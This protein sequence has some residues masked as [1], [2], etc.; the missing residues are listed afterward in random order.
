MVE[1]EQTLKKR[2]KIQ[3]FVGIMAMVAVS[4]FIKKHELLTAPGWWERWCP[5]SLF[6][7]IFEQEKFCLERFL[8]S[9]ALVPDDINRFLTS[10]EMT[11]HLEYSG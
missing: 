8:F 11:M 10:F 4:F 5:D 1:K 6:F 3:I 9:L 7:C 2:A